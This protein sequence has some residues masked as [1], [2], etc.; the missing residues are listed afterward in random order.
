MNSEHIGDERDRLKTGV[1]SILFDLIKGRIFIDAL[2]SDSTQNWPRDNYEKSLGLGKYRKRIA[3]SYDKHRGR[4]D[5]EK[6]KEYPIVFLDPDT[7]VSN[8][9][10]DE[11]HVLLSDISH[12]LTKKNVICIYDQSK[13]RNDGYNEHF[14]KLCNA[15]E[16]NIGYVYYIMWKICCVTFLFMSRDKSCL[17]IIY[18][19]LVRKYGDISVS[20][21]NL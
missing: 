3:V 6:Y 10:K 15:I 18:N 17:K 12:I 11:K 1:L 13:D 9:K 7:G 4:I 21:C 2:V 14:E 20:Q 19:R 16:N 5:K 8:K